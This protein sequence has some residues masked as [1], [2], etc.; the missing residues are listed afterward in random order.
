MSAKWKGVKKTPE[1]VKKHADAIRGR[2]MPPRS[3]EWRR[4]LSEAN[5]G[6][7]Q[8]WVSERNRGNKYGLGKHANAGTHYYN[9]GE[10]EVRVKECPEGFVKGRLKR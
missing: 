4:K 5:K 7:K 9:N 6:K 8:P 3:D 1:Q 2:K 10:V